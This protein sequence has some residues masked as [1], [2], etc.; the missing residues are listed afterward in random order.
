MPGWSDE[1]THNDYTNGCVFAE[2]FILHKH[3]VI[4]LGREQ[5]DIF[6]TVQP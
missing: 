3:P 1:Q 2:H 6:H 5:R 4:S